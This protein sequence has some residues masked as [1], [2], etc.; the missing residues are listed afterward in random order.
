[1]ALTSENEKSQ[2]SAGSEAEQRLALQGGCALGWCEMSHCD[3]CPSR[4]NGRPL[5]HQ[6]A[7]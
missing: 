5:Y 3:Y 6:H 2:A 4:D 1:M 7:R